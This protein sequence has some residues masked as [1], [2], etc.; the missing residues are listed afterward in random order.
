M[1]IIKESYISLW[2]NVFMLSYGCTRQCG[3]TFV[4]ANTIECLLHCVLTFSI[5]LL[6]NINR[7][8]LY[9]RDISIKMFWGQKNVDISYAKNANPNWIN[10]STYVLP[11]ELDTNED[12]NLHLFARYW[13]QRSNKPFSTTWN[14]SHS[15]QQ[16]RSFW[17]TSVISL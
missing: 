14:I 5:C 16:N 6:F 11:W 12:I 9:L 17:H 13:Q 7:F 15:K 3:C 10:E 4:M 2:C 8:C 1:F